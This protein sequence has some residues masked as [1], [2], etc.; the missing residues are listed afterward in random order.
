MPVMAPALAILLTVLF[1]TVDGL[2]KL[3]A[4]AVMALVPPVMFEIVFPVTVFVGAFP[5]SPSVLLNPVNADAPVR[6]IFEKLLLVIVCEDPFTDE[7]F[8]DH[9]VVLPAAVRVK[10]VTIEFP[11]RVKV[12]PEINDGAKMKNVTVPVVLTLM[13][14]K[15]LPFIVCVRGFPA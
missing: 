12:A 11:L 8:D 6:T 4:M 9:I 2:L 13:F 10:L 1:V 15:V 5:L 7:A 3:T 14:V